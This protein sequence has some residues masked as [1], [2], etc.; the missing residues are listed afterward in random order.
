MPKNGETTKTRLAPPK[1]HGAT[2]ALISS[3]QPHNL[4]AC[5]PLHYNYQRRRY[6]IIHVEAARASGQLRKSRSPRLA[7]LGSF[8]LER[9]INLVY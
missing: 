5:L 7:L 3:D 9:L 6:V 8:R 4:P 1:R 2:E